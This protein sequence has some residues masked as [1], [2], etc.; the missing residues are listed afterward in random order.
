[1]SE[2]EK[3]GMISY[4]SIIRNDWEVK[5]SETDGSICV[6]MVNTLTMHSAV[7]FFL[8]PVEA[9]YWI[10]TVSQNY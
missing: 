8:D 6:F 5:V 7:R 2:L 10:E 1:M 3:T 9:M 4:P